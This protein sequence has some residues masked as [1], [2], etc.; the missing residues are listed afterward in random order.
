M[1]DGAP[2][3]ALEIAMEKLAKRDAEAGGEPRSLTDAQR[4]AIG[5]AR[6]EHEA[7]VAE[8]RILH[9]AKLAATFDPEARRTLDEEYRRDLARFESARDKKIRVATSDDTAPED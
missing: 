9:E 4:E 8:C 6:R 1:P 2:K 5:A 3:S 7:K